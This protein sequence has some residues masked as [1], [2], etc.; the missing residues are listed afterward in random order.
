MLNAHRELQADV[1]VACMSVPLE[2]ASAFGVVGVA[3][4]GLIVDFQEKPSSPEPYPPEPGHALVSMGVYSFTTESL[5][6]ELG[7]GGK[8]HSNDFGK[9]ILPSLIGRAGVC[10][11]QFGGPSG[12]VTAD[13]YWRDLG[14]ID[15][16]FE[17]NQDL[18]EPLPL[19][20]LYQPDWQ[21]RTYETQNPP[22]RTT[23]G[24]SGLDADCINSILCSG[25]IIAGGRVNYSILSPSVRVGEGADLERAIL[26]EGVEVG[27][28][29][30]LRR[31]IID[32]HVRI[33]P[34]EA[35][36]VDLEGDRK[37]F[38]VSD[39]GVVVVPRLHEFS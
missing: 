38:T 9:D 11:Y 19:M 30:R 1:V 37:R 28:G 35:I 36:G 14:T 12:R 26:F 6:T 29:A 13:R 23:R 24:E 17:A 7:G 32:K 10:A 20:N 18:L 21:I 31:C 34:G 5:M 15:A 2:E 3:A 27:A 39:A 4:A 8:T 33:P 22:A 16:Y 25:A